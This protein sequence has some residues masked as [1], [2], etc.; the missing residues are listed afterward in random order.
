MRKEKLWN[1]FYT[2]KDAILSE[3][4]FQ[5]TVFLRKKQFLIKK[6]KMDCEGWFESKVKPVLHALKSRILS[7]CTVK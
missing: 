7:D 1:K 3:K 5:S 4:K 6:H 2:R